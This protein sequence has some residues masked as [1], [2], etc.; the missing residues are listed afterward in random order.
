M[1][2]RDKHMETTEQSKTRWPVVILILVIVAGIIGSG[3]VLTGREADNQDSEATAPA[4]QVVI[5]TSGLTPSTVK[6]RK[7]QSVIWTNQDSAS[8][9]IGTSDKKLDGFTGDNHIQQGESFAYVFDEPG[10]YRYYDTLN[11]LAIKGEG[12]VEE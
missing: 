6:V 4:G 11:P 7:G 5:S 9:Q 1:T 12:V 2:E 10:T 8:H 3:I